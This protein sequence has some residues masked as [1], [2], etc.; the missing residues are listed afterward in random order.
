ML[1]A[2]SPF[3]I[4]TQ[5]IQKTYDQITALRWIRNIYR[6]GDVSSTTFSD[7]NRLIPVKVQSVRDHLLIAIGHPGKIV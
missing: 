2:K 4:H 3:S 5:S 1:N 7:L 6:P